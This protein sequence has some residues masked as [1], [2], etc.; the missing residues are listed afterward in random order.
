MSDWSSRSLVPGGC[1][2]FSVALADRQSSLLV[3][4]PR[5]A[6]LCHPPLT[7]TPWPSA[8]CPNTCMQYGR[9]RRMTVITRN[10]GALLKSS[11]S[12]GLAAGY[13]KSG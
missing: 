12:R 3:D 4:E 6:R 9:Y 5:Q 13:E 11:F 1:F 8:S 10:A 7:F 2:F